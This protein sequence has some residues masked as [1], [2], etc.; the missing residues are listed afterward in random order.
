VTITSTVERTINKH[1]CIRR[2]EMG[3]TRWDDLNRGLSLY[4][5]QAEN[6]MKTMIDDRR[7]VLRILHGK[8]D[9]RNN[10][11]GKYHDNKTLICEYLVK[12]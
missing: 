7:E 6:L 3:H 5:L 2:V 8:N 12:P 11:K 10:F 1:L 9:D 4:L